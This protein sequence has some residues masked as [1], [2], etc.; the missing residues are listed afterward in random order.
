MEDE[1]NKMKLK[2]L[3]L[4]FSLGYLPIS[5]FYSYKLLELVKGTELLWFIWWLSVPAVI[6][7]QILSKLAEWEEDDASD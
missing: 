4:V 2:V 6:I 7:S 1:T 5:L 3:S